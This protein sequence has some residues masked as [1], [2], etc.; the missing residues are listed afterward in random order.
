[1]HFKVLE[2]ALRLHPPG[3]GAGRLSPSAGMTPITSSIS[4]RTLSRFIVVTITTSKKISVYCN[5]HELKVILLHSQYVRFG[6]NTKY[7]DS[8]CRMRELGEYCIRS[9]IKALR[10]QEDVPSDLLTMI[11][12][13][14]GE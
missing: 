14:I 13:S 7:M 11:L 10:N 12:S 6:E 9:R 2:E 1:M 5:M 8:M 4:S 3:V